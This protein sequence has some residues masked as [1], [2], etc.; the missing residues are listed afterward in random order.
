MEDIL[1]LDGVEQ[2]KLVRTRQI[3]ADELVAAAIRRIERLDPQINALTQRYFDEA[4]TSARRGLPAGPFRGVPFLVKDFYCHMQGKPTIGGSRLLASN[5]IDHDS[6]LM[7]RYRRAGFVTLGKTA[8]PEMVTIGTT[9]ASSSGPTRNPWNLGHTAGGSSGGSAAAVAAGMVSIAHANDGAGS[10]RIPA[11]FCGLYGLKPSRGRITLGPDVGESIGGITAEH[12][13]TRSVRDSAAVLDATA[14]GMPGDPYVTTEDNGSFLAATK[15]PPRRLRIAVSY[16][17]LFET[18]L[19]P[20]CRRAV[21]EAARLLEA[22]GHMIEIAKPRADAEVFRNALASFWPMTIAR[23]LSALATAR[24]VDVDVLAA[25]LEPLNQHLFRL[26]RNRLAVD[27]IQDLVTFQSLTRSFGAFFESFDL[28]LTPTVTFP[29][30]RLGF[31]DPRNSSDEE[32]YRRVIDSFAFTAPAN[33]CGLPAASLPT[34]WADSGLPIGVQLTGPLG[35]EALI[36]S[37]SAEIEAAL[38]WASLRP[39]EPLSP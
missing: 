13:V 25:E 32:A 22:A 27:Y 23:A 2:A 30:P 1:R 38:D 34:F 35:S 6:E 33:V 28:W 31:F 20:D 26:G 5:I 8:V 16:E 37:V 17:A 24:A 4:L 21:E 36:L 9:E 10:T 12:A 18:E 7:A 29:P 19:A 15:Q 3:R 11:T 39:G 14:G